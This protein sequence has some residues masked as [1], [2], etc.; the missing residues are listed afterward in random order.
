MDKYIKEQGQEITNS[1]GDYASIQHLPKDEEGVIIPYQLGNT[2]ANLLYAYICQLEEENECLKQNKTKEDTIISKEN[3]FKVWK[4]SNKE[5]ILNQY[6]SYYVTSRKWAKA[7]NE[8]GK[9]I[10]GINEEERS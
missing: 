10:D 6:Y 9:I 4:D 2:D 1:I 3:F 5:N 8:I 7:L